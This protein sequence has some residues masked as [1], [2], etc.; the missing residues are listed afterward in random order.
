[1]TY[2]RVSKLVNKERNTGSWA[3]ALADAENR[4]ARASEKDKTRWEGVIAIIQN[5]IARGEPWPGG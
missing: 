3:E 2:K 1:M 4:R 5:A